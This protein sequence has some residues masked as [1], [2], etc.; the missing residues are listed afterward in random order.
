[1]L[2]LPYPCYAEKCFSWC[3]TSDRISRKITFLWP[4]FFASFYA[5]LLKNQRSATAQK[6]FNLLCDG[7][8]TALMPAEMS[9]SNRLG[10][11][12]R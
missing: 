9:Y 7:R 2:S 11:A 12:F 3:F 4:L 6:T 1:V 8:F 5:I 10:R